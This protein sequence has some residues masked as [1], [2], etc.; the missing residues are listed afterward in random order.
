MQFP[1]RSV[2]CRTVH[3]SQPARPRIYIYVPLRCITFNGRKINCRKFYC[4]DLKHDQ[5]WPHINLQS[6]SMIIACQRD[7][8]VKA[9]RHQ[10]RRQKDTDENT[11]ISDLTSALHLARD[12]PSL[13]WTTYSCEKV[14]CVKET[15]QKVES[16]KIL[17]NFR[18]TEQ[19]C[20]TRNEES[21][22]ICKKDDVR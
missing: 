6:A 10:G 3:Q 7:G 9:A 8:Q 21:N 18:P 17:A 15:W 5:I 14:T 1:L 20:E 12:S 13:K 2:P 22:G 11:D 4:V 16:L 19:R